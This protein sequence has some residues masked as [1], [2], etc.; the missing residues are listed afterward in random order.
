MA[1]DFVDYILR[2]AHILKTCNYKVVD[3]A[4]TNLRKKDDVNQLKNRGH[5]SVLLANKDGGCRRLHN[6]Q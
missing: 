6:E 5:L 4:K 3:D 1:A 2:K